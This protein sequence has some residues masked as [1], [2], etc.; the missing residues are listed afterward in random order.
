MFQGY[1]MK[2]LIFY[3][4][5]ARVN[6]TK[7]ILYSFRYI[8]SST[9][10]KPT[11]FGTLQVSGLSICLNALKAFAA[12]RICWM[13]RI[14][15]NQYFFHNFCFIEQIQQQHIPSNRT[16]IKKYFWLHKTSILAHFPFYMLRYSTCDFGPIY[17]SINWN[18]SD[19]CR[20]GI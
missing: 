1:G 17:F 19:N 13:E 9:T 11:L 14:L 18:Y 2:I 15:M 4:C 16:T 7:N 20:N 3:R 8:S 5:V 6:I 10:S 12:F